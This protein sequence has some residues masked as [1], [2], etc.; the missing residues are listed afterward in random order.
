MSLLVLSALVLLLALVPVLVLSVLTQWLS[1]RLTAGA[2][3]VFHKPQVNP[4][5][6]VDMT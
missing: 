1:R 6:P 3:R 2:S 5:K 4:Q